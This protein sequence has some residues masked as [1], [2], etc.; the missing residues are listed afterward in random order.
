M[1]NLLCAVA[2]LAL[3]GGA[4][5]LDVGSVNFKSCEIG[6]P[7]G[8]L[9]K[10]ECAYLGVPENP[11]EHSGKQI[12]I[13]LALIA[14][15]AKKPE[16]DPV[17]FLAGGPGQ[18][19]SESFANV[20]RGFSEILKHRHVI[21]YDQRGTGLSNALRCDDMDD[22]DSPLLPT[23]AERVQSIQKATKA[24]LQSLKADVRFYN[25]SSAITD[26]E[27]IRK[28]LGAKQINLF[29]I[30]YGTRMAQQY[31]MNYP[32]STR[33][34]IIDGVAPNEMILGA[35]MARDLDDA[36]AAQFAACRADKACF[37]RFGD[38]AQTLAALRT[39]LGAEQR[40]L[41]IA[42]PLTGKPIEVALA[43]SAIVLVA[44]FSAYMSEMASMLPLWLDE[45]K[46]GRPQALLAQG[47][48]SADGLNKMFSQ[49][50]YLSVICSEDAEFL[51]ANAS[52][53]NRLV[54]TAMAD[55]MAVQCPLWPKGPRNKNFFTP[56]KTGLPVLLISGEWDPV[57]PAR[58]GE[59]ILKN[60]SN[61]VHIVAPRQGH[62]NLLRGC[63]PKLAG[64]FL[65]T[66]Q[67][68]MLDVSCV[69][70]ITGAPFFLDYTGPSP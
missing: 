59:Q 66:L 62:G 65:T 54:G 63:I 5:A 52:D 35:D 23:D 46:N 49:G 33:S 11:A 34:L 6:A 26:L 2:L 21:L 48:M 57:T 51:K 39:Q 47:K 56:L 3:S 16:A 22:A 15:S 1:K 9:T 32:S 36:L 61:A 17:I 68:K 20:E 50:M 27:A 4:C 41:A 42:D 45:A 28:A 64:N 67:P 25:T 40:T 58:Y 12:Q 31:A 8:A 7:G 55:M 14:S 37:A 43:P 60:L 30:S 29:G 18:A 38:P 19:A 10:A 53:A 44:R 70:K 69:K 24:C 13:H